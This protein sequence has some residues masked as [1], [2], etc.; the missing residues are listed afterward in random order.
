[1]DNESEIINELTEYFRRINKKMILLKL[2]MQAK[3]EY[4]KCDFNAGRRTLIEAYLLDK[5][6][7]AVLRGLGCIKQ[8]EGKFNSAIRYFKTALKYSKN[9]EIEYSLLGMAYYIQE[10]LDDAVEYFN[11]AIDCN[12]N[13]DK[14]YE[15][16]NQAMLERHLKIVN[17]QENLNKRF[18]S[19]ANDEQ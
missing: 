11:L 4:D 3:S 19:L 17:L 10:R 7:P 18:K 12:D 8:F 16:R 1:M 13:Y 5:Q 9:K 15:G 2:V 6:S 14:A